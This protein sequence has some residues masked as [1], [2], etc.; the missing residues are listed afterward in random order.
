MFGTGW[1]SGSR[2]RRRHPT[3]ARLP[4]GAFHLVIYPRDAN[5]VGGEVVSVADLGSV[6]GTMT[7]GEPDEAPAALDVAGRTA[8]DFDPRKRLV[9]S[10]PASAFDFGANRDTPFSFVALFRMADTAQRTIASTMDVVTAGAGGFFAR[11]EGGTVL[12][13]MTANGGGWSGLVPS[14]AL[15][16]GWHV[17]IAQWG[18]GAFAHFVDQGATPYA[19]GSYSHPGVGGGPPSSTMKHGDDNAFAVRGLGAVGVWPRALDEGE[20]GAVVSGLLDELGLT[21]PAGLA[22]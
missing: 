17:L 19:T 13:G 5:V 21:E 16:T 20:R 8:A 10:A 15:A 2:R 6:G 7:P 3:G 1:R 12:P 9:H 22:A 11:V 18:G 4:S 14:S